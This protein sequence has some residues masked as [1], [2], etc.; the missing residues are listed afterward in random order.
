M[1]HGGGSIMLCGSFS[2]AGKL[3]RDEG[4]M[5]G[6]KSRIIIEENLLQFMRYFDTGAE[7]CLPTGQ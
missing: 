1:K 4:E 2:S 5:D 3:I 6:G 7:L